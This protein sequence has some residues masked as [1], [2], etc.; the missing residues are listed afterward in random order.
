MNTLNS[1]SCLTYGQ[2]GEILSDYARNNHFFSG[3]A[4]AVS[5]FCDRVAGSHAKQPGTGNFAQPRSIRSRILGDLSYILQ[6]T[7]Y[8][9]SRQELEFGN[10]AQPRSIPSRIQGNLSY[11]LQKILKGTVTQDS[12][13]FFFA[14]FCLIPF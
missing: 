13:N 14:F 3:V 12:R 10:I 6:K 2:K 9:H 8:T 7:L 11:I 5:E 4:K 1:N